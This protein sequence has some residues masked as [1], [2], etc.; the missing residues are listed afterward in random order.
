MVFN[1]IIIGIIISGFILFCGCITI[2]FYKGPEISSHAPTISHVDTSFPGKST[3][4]IPIAGTMEK[5]IPL[6]KA[7]TPFD[8]TTYPQD[9]PQSNPMVFQCIW[10]GTGSVYLSGNKSSLT[11]VYADDGYEIKIQPS[12]DLF[13][14]P[15]HYAHQHPVVDLTRGMRTGVNNFT[16]IIK[17]WQGLSMSYGSINGIDIDQNPYIIQ[18]HR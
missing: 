1:K 17:N 6:V 11:G 3:G 7:G 4:D 14:A 16:L 8:S 9:T 15:E 12:G 18:V 5:I 13:D 10:D 2:N